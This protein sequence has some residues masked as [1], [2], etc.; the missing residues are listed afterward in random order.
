M[1]MEKMRIVFAAVL[2]AVAI[3]A[4][5]L[6]FRSGAAEPPLYENVV[7]PPAVPIAAPPADTEEAA[8]VRTNNFEVTAPTGR[9][10]RLLADAAERQR[11]E[12]AVLW[13]GKELPAWPERC[14]IRVKIQ[15]TGT[16]G[17]TTF[18]FDKGKVASRSMNVEGPLDGLL[19]SVLPHEITHTIL[20]D[21]FGA[22]LPRWADEGAAVLSEDEE[23]QQRYAGWMREI[24]AKERLI[25]LSRLLDLN[26]FPGDLM[27]LFAEG[28]SLT[29]FL[30][31]RKDRKTFLAFIKRGSQDGWDK[32]VKEHYAFRDVAELECAWLDAVGKK[33]EPE[34]RVISQ[35][36]LART[37][38]PEEGPLPGVARLQPD[39]KGLVLEVTRTKVVY[40]AALIRSP[41]GKTSTPE[42]LA[43]VRNQ[44][45]KIAV[46][47]SEVK[48]YDRDGKA[49]DPKQLPDLLKKERPILA[50]PHRSVFSDQLLRLVKE[51]TLLI[52]VKA[53]NLGENKE[54]SPPTVIPSPE[55]RRP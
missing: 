50:G 38:L 26:K 37:G 55:V 36:P 6:G 40:H 18:A 27:A 24:V 51:D 13:L 52:V 5:A 3:G 53:V 22:P 41:D 35:M 23:E 47:L 15:A 44:Q 28:H 39:G 46:P 20:A 8:T 30:V 12:K 31:E 4:V 7:P 19:S 14:P 2:A 48:A 34:Q 32:A 49:I 9:I 10:A 17:A 43:T 11:K 21:F 29:R 16:G 33:K 42:T 54:A 1:L 25:P 45:L